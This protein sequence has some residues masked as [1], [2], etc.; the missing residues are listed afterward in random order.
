MLT[1]AETAAIPK[2]RHHEESIVHHVGQ[3]TRDLHHLGL[4]YQR[5]IVAE[6][7]E[8]KLS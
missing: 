5:M 4:I 6:T 3:D 8:C 7:Q 1:A 2:R